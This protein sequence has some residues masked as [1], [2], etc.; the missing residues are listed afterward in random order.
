V[1]GSLYLLDTLLSPAQ[2][3]DIRHR[4]A[5]SINAPAGWI[6][7]RV[8]EYLKDA[9]LYGPGLFSERT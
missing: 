6:P 3:S 2:S 1:K 9:N 5:A 8:L 4:I 7:D